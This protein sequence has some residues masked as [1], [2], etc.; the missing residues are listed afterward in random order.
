MGEKSPSY[1]SP[2]SSGMA[3]RLVIVLIVG[4]IALT[5]QSNTPPPPKICGTQNGPPVTSTRTK[6]KDGRHVAYVEFGVPKNEAKHKI[7]FIHG[8]K[9]FRYDAL[10]VSKEVLEELS[11]YLIGFDRPGYGESDPNPKKTVKSIATDI[12][13]MADNLQLGP[14]FYV[15]GFSMGGEAVWSVLKHIPHRLAGAALL[16]PVAN[17][18]WSGFPTNIIK[19]S[20]DV[21]LP[22][23]KWAVWIAHH[24][25]RLVYWWN[26]QKYFPKSSVLDFDPRVFSS[27][28]FQVLPKLANPTRLSFAGQILQQG[29]YESLHRDM[30][31]GFGKWDFSP[32]EIENPFPNNEGSVHIWHGTEDLIVPVQMSRYIA[33]K[34]TWIQYHEL[35]ASGHMFPIADGMADIIVKSLLLEKID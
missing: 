28:D 35:P 25:P 8:F 32:L 26:T 21:Q 2:P 23:D 13:E 31:V 6:L 30:I 18:W 29:E 11:I 9:S 34:L 33:Q 7:I 27:A 17:F 5:Y 10:P 20:W 1:S 19:E 22:Q 14:K 24:F 3:K 16:G 15:I 12:E 4:L